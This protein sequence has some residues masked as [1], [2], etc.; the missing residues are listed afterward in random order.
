MP[1]DVVPLKLGRRATTDGT[2]E[3]VQL[4]QLGLLL[5]VQ[6]DPLSIPAEQRR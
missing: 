1:G 2:F 4:Q 3:T 6:V 5:A